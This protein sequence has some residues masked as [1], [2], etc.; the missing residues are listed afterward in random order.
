MFESPTPK[1]KNLTECRLVTTSATAKWIPITQTKHSRKLQKKSWKPNIIAIS[2]HWSPGK[3]S[4]RSSIQV[5]W[6]EEEKRLTGTW[7][8]ISCILSISSLTLVGS[9]ALVLIRG[10]LIFSR[11][12]SRI[13]GPLPLP[14][15]A[16]N[17]WAPNISSSRDPIHQLFQVNKGEKSN[18]IKDRERNHLMK[19]KQRQSLNWN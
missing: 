4:K 17:G 5:R 11:G 14:L 9:L 19:L 13:I 3:Q 1:E 8:P 7:S 10:L 16:D 15:P 6:I 18:Q 12:S 2:V